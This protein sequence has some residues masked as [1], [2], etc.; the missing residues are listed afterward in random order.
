ME[1]EQDKDQAEVSMHEQTLS[2]TAAEGS[3]NGKWEDPDRAEIATSEISDRRQ[4]RV[5]GF[6]TG[7]VVGEAVNIVVVL[8]MSM[9][10]ITQIPILASICSG[11]VVLVQI[12]VVVRYFK[13]GNTSIAAGILAQLAIVLLVFGGCVVQAIR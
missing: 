6:T 13:N 3:D 1:N 4:N 2:S 11:V 5:E 8:L 12:V 10:A 9:L 7:C